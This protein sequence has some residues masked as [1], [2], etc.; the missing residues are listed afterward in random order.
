MIYDLIIIG[1]GSAG[2]TAAIY[3]A[4][5]KMNTL[6]LTKKIGDRPSSF[7][8]IENFPG[9]LKIRGTELNEKM[10]EQVA[11]YGVPI[12]EDM[13]VSGIEKKDGNFL[14]KTE[15]GENFET[16]TVIIASGRKPKKLEAPGAKEFETKGVSFCTVCDAPIFAGKNVAVIGGG[17]TA[18]LSALDLLPYANQIYLLQHNKKFI[19]DEAII[20]KLKASGKVHFFA[21]AETIEIKGKQFVESLV[22]EDMET[23]EKK[24]LKVGGVFIS[25]GQFPNTEFAKGLVNLN[26]QGEIIIDPLTTQSSTEGIFAAGDSANIPYKQ[27]VIAAGEGAKSA[28]SAHEYLLK[29]KKYK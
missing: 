25:I 18:L 22:Y 23:K 5:K 26:E 17:N 28:L 8:E 15:A 9:F 10:I 19:G 16:K 24:E 14:V 11:R 13:A 6:I 3:A 29:I 2:L 7:Y 21:N 27:C 12:K 20:E 4:R 1:S